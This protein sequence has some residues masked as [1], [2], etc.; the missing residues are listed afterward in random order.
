MPTIDCKSQPKITNLDL[1]CAKC[2]GNKNKCNN[3][4]CD[5]GSG[6]CLCEPGYSG[7]NCET[8]ICSSA[9]C[10]NGICAAKYLGGDL[11]ITIK[12]CVCQEGWFGEK[13]DTRDA[14]TITDISTLMPCEGHCTGY[15]PYSCD[16]N[17]KLVIVEKQQAHVCIIIL[18]IHFIV[19]TKVVN[20]SRA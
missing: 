15:Y 6:L 9:D 20:Q 3:G 13:C 19:A 1:N 2:Q 11:P 18:Q 8:N 17:Q 10:V 14:S 7:L 5:C 4:F 16:L 12:G